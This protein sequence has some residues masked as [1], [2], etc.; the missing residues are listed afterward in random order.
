[1]FILDDILFSP[2]KGLIWLAGKVKEQAE[3]KLYNVTALKEVLQELQ[4]RFDAGEVSQ[5]EYDTLEKKYLKAI[6]EATKYHE[7]RRV[8]GLEK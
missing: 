4:N 6:E 2:V 3:D 5:E 1:M 7:Q 8:Q